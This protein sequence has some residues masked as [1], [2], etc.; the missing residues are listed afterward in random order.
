METERE[1]NQELMLILHGAENILR[2]R[3]CVK[4]TRFVGF[5]FW[6]EVIIEMKLKLF[7]KGKQ[8]DS[9][10]YRRK[11]CMCQGAEWNNEYIL[12]QPI[13]EYNKDPFMIIY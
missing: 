7:T 13:G 1:S 8:N 10:C 2:V 5:D 12:L 9:K 6:T 11:C 3:L 4:N